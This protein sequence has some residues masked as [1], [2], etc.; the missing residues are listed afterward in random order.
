[1]KLITTRN[2]SVADVHIISEIP[3]YHG[4]L[5]KPGT[6]ITFRM[7]VP[8]GLK[9]FYKDIVKDNKPHFWIGFIDEDASL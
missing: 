2:N 1:M 5:M 3:E 8:E 9:V 7:E 6:E 4:L